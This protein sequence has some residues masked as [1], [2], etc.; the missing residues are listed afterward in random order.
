M[1]SVLSIVALIVALAALAISA[2]THM[3]PPRWKHDLGASNPGDVV[4]IVQSILTD[5][6]KLQAVQ[7]FRAAYRDQILRGLEVVEKSESGDFGIVFFRYSIGT[8]V[9]RQAY[10]L[11][12][13]NG[14]WYWIPHLSKYSDSKP[15]DEQWFEKMIEKKEDWE[16]ESAKLKFQ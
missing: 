7:A 5:D 6:V 12:K 2:Y 11:G 14:K 15:A 3:N 1:K 13:V 16:K 10:W 8:D 9:F 4:G